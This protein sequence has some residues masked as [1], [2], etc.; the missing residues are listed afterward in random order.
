VTKV[1]SLQK[2]VVGLGVVVI[3]VIVPSVISLKAK[4]GKI[5][6]KN[7]EEINTWIV[8]CNDICSIYN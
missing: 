8:A 2:L 3:V 7:L 6:K 4:R 5:M 1:P